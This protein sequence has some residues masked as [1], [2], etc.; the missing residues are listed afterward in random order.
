[1]KTT[2]KDYCKE[3]TDCRFHFVEKR[4]FAKLNTRIKKTTTFLV[5]GLLLI[6]FF[7]SGLKAIDISNPD[8]GPGS[9]WIALPVYDIEGDTR[10]GDGTSSIDIVGNNTYPSVF[11]QFL[12][13]GDSIA[14]R[15]RV[16]N[17]DGPAGTPEFHSFA[18]I[19]ID[20]NLNGTVD[21]FIG[22]YDPSGI[23]R[24]GI[25]LADPLAN[26]NITGRTGITDPVATFQPLDGVNYS[27]I[28]APGS[29]FSGNPDYFISFKF[30]VADV[31]TA[32]AG[33]TKEHVS[34]SKEIPFTFIS[35]TSTQD[36][37]KYGDT[38]G[39]DDIYGPFLPWT[40]L[41]QH[42]LST[43]G[44]TWYIVNFDK[45]G[46]DVNAY[47]PT[48]AIK[49]GNAITISQFPIRNPIKRN[50][51]HF[52]GWSNIPND[53]APTLTDP[54]LPGAII[55][56]NKTV[57]A[58]WI[59]TGIDENLEEHIVHFDPTGG[60]LTAPILTVTWPTPP[61]NFRDVLSDDGCIKDMPPT[62]SFPTQSAGGGSSW[63]FGGWVTDSKVYPGLTGQLTGLRNVIDIRGSSPFGSANTINYFLSSQWVT[64]LTKAYQSHSGEQEYS[65]Y[66]LWLSKGNNVSITLSFYDN[67]YPKPPPG[68][69]GSP[70]D[71]VYTA[72]ISTNNSPFFAPSPISRQGF[73]FRGWDT[74]PNALP[75]TGGPTRY[76]DPLG[77]GVVNTP[78]Q[79]L[80]SSGAKFTSNTNFYAVWEAGHYALQFLP[81]TVDYVLDPL[82]GIPSGTFGYVLC[83]YIPNTINYPNPF[84]APPTLAGYFFVGWNTLPDG[85]GF[86]VD[87]FGAG[88]TINAGQP[89]KY[90]LMTRMNTNVTLID[91]T[92]LYLD[93][94]TTLYAL[95]ERDP[96]AVINTIV[97]FDA[98]GGQHNMGSPYYLSGDLNHHLL[99]VPAKD[100]Y[101]LYLPTPV[102]PNIDDGSPLQ[103]FSGW[104]FSNAPDRT[105]ANPAI[106]S[107]ISD[108]RLLDV[109]VTLYAVWTP[110][111]TVIFH[112]RGGVW[113]D[114]V[115][116][117]S[118]KVPTDANGYA[119]Y[120]PGNF[121]IP[122]N[123]PERVGYEFI[124]W[125][126]EIDGGGIVYHRD[127]YVVTE[128][129]LNI[130]AQWKW[131][132]GPETFYTDIFY[133]YNDGTGIRFSDIVL[134]GSKITPPP[135][136]VRDGWK[137]GG[138]YR[139]SACINRW[140]F[141]NDIA[142]GSYIILYARWVTGVREYIIINRHITTGIK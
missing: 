83:P 114:G 35:G 136:P 107:Y 91:G 77:S 92:N 45:N 62:P 112:P 139:E 47:L 95:W 81:N 38:N 76:L 88:A 69:S 25:Y 131:I 118:I 6:I 133:D 40:D 23:G 2:Y 135:D 65:V 98:M 78:E 17:C 132:S 94:Y 51:W 30:C 27:F 19:G 70:G 36:S 55:N 102:W 22:V 53:V 58:T 9:G 115:S 130:Y 15:I 138:W 44:S 24:L 73:I 121:D 71:L 117:G 141:A 125:N 33:L 14:V 67:I 86:F 4:N 120:V 111:N 105:V 103:I 116:T 57:Y 126:T 142:T 20:A 99:D 79:W 66:A 12:S 84:P 48:S 60:N 93:G 128:K 31:S 96:N 87:E 64:E 140:N 97:T 28:M 42:P 124:G 49:A 63:V 100:G 89:V 59:Y 34:F 26:N 8:V 119:V 134:S 41:F 61:T 127:T 13:N 113:E 74:N 101:L 110:I 11:Y 21:F 129:V 106:K 104:S 52:E 43:D 5:F 54:F 108:P 56:S 1:V 18:F 72:S 68:A 32:I 50:G 90:S 80:N 46:G 7:P 29:N 85:S 109:N 137:F 122:D 16:N 37:F 123:H 82:I 10:I 3:Q 39:L 75:N